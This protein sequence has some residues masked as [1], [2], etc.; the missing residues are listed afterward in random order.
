MSGRRRPR[1]VILGSGIVLLF[2]AVAFAVYVGVAAKPAGSAP[3][4]QATADS[5]T[6]VDCGDMAF[7][8]V[9]F[10]TANHQP[11]GAEIDILKSAATMLHKKLVVHQIQFNGIIAALLSKQCDI[12]AAGIFHTSERAKVAHYILYATNGQGMVV[13]KGNPAKITG[14]NASAAGKR[15]GMTSGYSTIPGIKAG[16]HKLAKQG[17]KPCTIVL[18]PS[19]TDN[20]NALLQDKTDAAVDSTTAVSYYAKINHNL[21]VANP[22][23]LPKSLVGFLV[24]KNDPALIAGMQRVVNTLYKN[25]GMCKIL[26]KYGIGVTALPGHHC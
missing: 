20:V 24:R 21:Q 15:L 6:L 10:Y 7:P 22:N 2:F 1:T 18:F 26:N 17:L 11:T 4:S 3:L 16:C 9:E 23:V 13:R 14:L 8:P 5:S 25:G 12:L 19:P